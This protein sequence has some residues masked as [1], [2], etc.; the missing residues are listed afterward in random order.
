MSQPDPSAT[1]QPVSI[2]IRSKNDGALIG[3]TLR[4]VLG[5]DYP[6]PLELIHIDS[7]ST[8]NTV[9]VIREFNP[10]KLI[11]IRADEYIPGV[12]L[13]RGMREASSQWVVFLNSDC[14]P[15]NP[16]W[17]SELLASARS[18]PGIGAAF[19][20]QMPR[21][22]C[23]AVYAHDYER[24]FGSSRESFRWDHFFSMA[25]SVVNRAAW[26]E[27]P[28][29]EDL[30]YSEDDEWSRRL[31]A[32]GWQVA[33]AEK[34]PVLHS[35]NYTL[36]QAFR[37][38]YGEAFAL[39]AIESID[40]RSHNIFRTVLAGVARESLRDFRYCARTGRLIEWPRAVAVRT[41]QR[42]GK[43]KGFRKGLA[44]YRSANFNKA[45]HPH[46]RPAHV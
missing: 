23:Q 36:A 34:A 43:L 38:C 8:D 4:G 9:E 28:F 13:N 3:A 46:H 21:P 30:Q 33:Y 42:L 15:A 12:V 29:R 7:G 41:A 40:E 24:C 44:H 18:A 31:V 5:Q 27:H 1:P 25:N 37:R 32:R 22:D 19:G 26:E 14:E 45:L 20:R 2:V 6:G 11:R 16:R 39:T 10:G 17:L 35:H